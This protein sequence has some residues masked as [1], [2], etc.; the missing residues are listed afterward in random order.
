[1]IDQEILKSIEVILYN[2]EH[3][4]KTGWKFYVA[5]I[6][7]GSDAEYI[8]YNETVELLRA[9]YQKL[10]SNKEKEFLLKSIYPKTGLLLLVRQPKAARLVLSH[11]DFVFMFFI[12]IKDLDRALKMITDRIII[13]STKGQLFH[14]LNEILYFE[15]NTF[16]NMKLDEILSMVDTFKNF[17]TNLKNYIK[18]ASIPFNGKQFVPSYDV[19]KLSEYK[20]SEFF[21]I[22]DCENLL[23]GI[24]RKAYHIEHQ[25]LSLSL[26]EGIN[27]EINQ[28]Q[29]QLQN[30]IVGFG[31]DKKLNE[32]IKKI[33]EK[34]YDA[35]DLFDFKNC[36]DLI[37][38]LLN[39]LCISIALEIQNKR[40]IQPTLIVDSMGRARSYFIDKRIKFLS[41]QEDKFVGEY[42]AFISDAGVHAL[43][44]E[45]EYARISR[46]LVIEIG[47]FLVE[48]LKKYLNQP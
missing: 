7:P 34:L 25:R 21:A 48:K 43:Q 12:K 35:K 15:P 17:I 46:N 27:Y 28:D 4:N 38:A 24:E 36:I 26:R 10:V 47:L 39:E 11:Q 13:T 6:R 29:D 41:E 3:S 32:T 22:K 2:A 45:R 40:H 19:G 1:M 20:A 5:K 42:N 8:Y 31:F 30:I 9:L 23:L 14:V 33:N 37:R 18:F 16:D 44:S